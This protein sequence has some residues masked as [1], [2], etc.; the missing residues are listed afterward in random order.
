MSTNDVDF[1]VIIPARYASTRLPGKPLEK[2]VGKT[3]I[4]HVYDRAKSSG[5]SRVIIATDD[6]RIQQVA[7]NIGAQVQMTSADH[8][9]GSDRIAEVV[10]RLAFSD[11]Q[12]VVNLQGDE[13]FMPASLIHQVASN[14][15]SV[16][17]DSNIGM[18]T[19]K[20]AITKAD[21]LFDPN[22]VKVVVD[23]G[24]CAV[25]FSRAPIP[26]DRETLSFSQIS[27]PTNRD[28][29]RH[30]GIYAY[31]SGFL[32]QYVSWPPAPIE[33]VESL[34]QLRVLWNDY[35]VHVAIADELPFPGVDTPEDLEKAIKNYQ[36]KLKLN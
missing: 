26:W 17:S 4:E 19:L 35:K 21:E 7:E 23:K 9:S 12:I 30:I 3:M 13:L 1:T 28:Y 29:Y 18:A 10:E 6:K 15:E 24:D 25:Y 36:D 34:E 8:T 27:L 33:I 5:A 16:K 22:V 32:K 31:R 14:L 2:I 11:E 20:T